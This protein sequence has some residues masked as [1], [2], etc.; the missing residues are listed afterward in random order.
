VGNAT[1]NIWAQNGARLSVLDNQLVRGDREVAGGVEK[2]VRFRVSRPLSN[3][4][5]LDTLAAHEPSKVI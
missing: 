2:C 4:S 3:L 5:I 1:N